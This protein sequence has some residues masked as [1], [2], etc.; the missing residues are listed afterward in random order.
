MFV[1]AVVCRVLTMHL[2][3]CSGKTTPRNLSGE[4][5]ESAAIFSSCQELYKSMWVDGWIANVIFGLFNFLWLLRRDL[6]LLKK[7]ALL[8]DMHA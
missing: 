7:Y 2:F 5:V 1:A 6:F 3:A 8:F 4:K